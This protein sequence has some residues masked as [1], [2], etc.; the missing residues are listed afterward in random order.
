MKVC[1][2]YVSPAINKLKKSKLINSTT[3]AIDNHFIVFNY[4][5]TLLPVV[6]AIIDGLQNMMK[7]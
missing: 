7:K 1:L 3:L 2:M 6:P 5:N 4:I